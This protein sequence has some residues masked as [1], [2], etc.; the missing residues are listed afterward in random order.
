LSPGRRPPIP[1]KRQPYGVDGEI[2]PRVLEAF[3]ITMPC[4]GAE[5]DLDSL[6]S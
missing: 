6:L 5:L 4:A 3:S 2:H 1:C